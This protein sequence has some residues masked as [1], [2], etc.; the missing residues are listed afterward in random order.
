MYIL[1]IYMWERLRYSSK[2]LS[3]ETLD[4]NSK[5]ETLSGSHSVYFLTL[6]LGFQVLNPCLS[7]YSEEKGYDFIRF[8]YRPFSHYISGGNFIFSNLGLGLS[9]CQLRDLIGCPKSK[10]GPKKW[11]WNHQLQLGAPIYTKIWSISNGKMVYTNRRRI[12]C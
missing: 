5:D 11:K 12:L 1:Y 2:I 10:N 6:S 4:Q 9:L 8:Q 3:W 7:W